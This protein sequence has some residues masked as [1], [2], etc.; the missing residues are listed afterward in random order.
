MSF[1]DVKKCPIYVTWL[2]LMRIDTAALAFYLA[3][4]VPARIAPQGEEVLVDQS[5]LCLH[6]HLSNT[7]AT[8]LSER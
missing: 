4:A 1:I 3:T 7:S 2:H 5:H 8:F 6:R